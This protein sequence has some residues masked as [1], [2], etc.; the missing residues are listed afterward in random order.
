MIESQPRRVT[1]EPFTDESEAR[2]C[3]LDPRY[4]PAMFFS[5]RGKSVICHSSLKCIHPCF[6]LHMMEGSGVR[7][8]YDGG[9][10]LCL[11]VLLVVL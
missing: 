4:Y 10:G 8:H 11:V 6:R 7:R 2:R 5:I 1:V 3:S 9:V